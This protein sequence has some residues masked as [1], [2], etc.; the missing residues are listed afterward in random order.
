MNFY[1]FKNGDVAGPFERQQLIDS[2]KSK[3]L[4]AEDFVK[5]EKSGDWVRLDSIINGLIADDESARE[6]RPQS[7]P[8][9]ELL[10]A[11]PTVDTTASHLLAQQAWR[12]S[13]AGIR[14]GRRLAY[15]ERR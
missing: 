8:L 12:L 5:T 4:G 14:K 6:V 1:V 10:Y 15:R 9:S 2:W 13:L 7:T 3:I 11:T